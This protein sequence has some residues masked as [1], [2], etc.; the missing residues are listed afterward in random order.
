[1]GCM[2]VECGG[3]LAEGAAEDED[4]VGAVQWDFLLEV[5]DVGVYD[6]CHGC[7]DEDASRPECCTLLVLQDQRVLGG[8]LGSP[9][10]GV[11]VLCDAVA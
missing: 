10:D 9:V 4:A 5:H 2:I 11:G 1:M 7:R 3:G 6:A 8:V